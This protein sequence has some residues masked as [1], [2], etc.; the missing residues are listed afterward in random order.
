MI[1]RFSWIP[2]CAGVT[3][4]L[5]HAPRAGRF[6]RP[7]RRGR[8]RWKLAWRRG[9]FAALVLAHA[10]AALAQNEYDLPLVTPASNL[11]QQGFVRII[12][13]SARTGTV[14]VH[15]IDDRGERFGPA[16]LELDAN[17]S[18]Q[19]NSGE[20]PASGC[21]PGSGRVPATGAWSSARTSTS[22]LSPTSAHRTA[23]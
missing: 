23:S 19:F 3:E 16:D 8:L 2:A 11:Q 20:T 14:R 13:R 21:P 1:H 6:R 18:V 5:R 22:S 7:R 15:A 12:N 4:A 17:E 9:L 10:P